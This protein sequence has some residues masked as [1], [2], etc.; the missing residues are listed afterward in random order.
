M[1][2][3]KCLRLYKPLLLTIFSVYFYF[4]FFYS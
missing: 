1:F 3:L 4:F 2:I